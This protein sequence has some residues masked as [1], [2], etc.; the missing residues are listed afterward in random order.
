MIEIEL[1][2]TAFN[3]AVTRRRRVAPRRC[4]PCKTSWQC[5]ASR[6]RSSRRRRGASQH[7]CSGAS[8]EG[9]RL[10]LRGHREELGTRGPGSPVPVQ[11]ELAPSATARTRS[12]R[13][14]RSPRS[15]KQGAT[16]VDA[17]REAVVKAVTTPP[18]TKVAVQRN[19]L[20]WPRL[21]C[22]AMVALFLAP[23]FLEYL[24]SVRTKALAL[25]KSLEALIVAV[26]APATD[27][28]SEP[29][30]PPRPSA[31]RPTARRRRRGRCSAPPRPPA[32]ACTSVGADR[33]RASAGSARCGSLERQAS[34][35]GGVFGLR[36]RSATKVLFGRAV[37]RPPA[38]IAGRTAAG[39]RLAVLVPRAALLAAGS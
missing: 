4:T 12:A 28:L 11:Q 39:P 6:P 3:S 8:L 35:R 23:G 9:R 24:I 1:L 2:L 31:H 21:A 17:A 27:A 29:V 14:R 37:R 20:R 25:E 13:R 10:H 30:A 18:T 15:S 22:G 36:R 33:P 26:A 32:S 38:A 7:R 5:W 16:V 34:V 19:S